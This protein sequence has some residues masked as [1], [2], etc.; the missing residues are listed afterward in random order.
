MFLQYIYAFRM[1][2]KLLP[3]VTDGGW[4]KE[5][6]MLATPFKNQKQVLSVIYNLSIH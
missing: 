1:L 5:W 2:M 4:E 6:Q 3:S